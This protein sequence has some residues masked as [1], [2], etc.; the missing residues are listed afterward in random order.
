MQTRVKDTVNEYSIELFEDG[1]VEKNKEI[2]EIIAIKEH[3]KRG[4]V[5]AISDE[6]HG[7][8][9]LQSVYE[10]NGLNTTIN[11][12]MVWERKWNFKCSVDSI[13]AS[14]YTVQKDDNKVYSKL[15]EEIE[16]Y[17]TKEYGRYGKYIELLS[18]I[19]I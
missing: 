12:A 8:E 14:I 18:K 19:E 11:K 4:K 15:K 3:E 1:K 16:K 7:I 5:F 2:H 9:V 10:K 17:L 13:Q 6:Y